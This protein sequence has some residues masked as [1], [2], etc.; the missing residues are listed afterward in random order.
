MGKSYPLFYTYLS[1][2]KVKWN[3]NMNLPISHS[4]VYEGVIL[5]ENRVYVAYRM[6]AY[7]ATVKALLSTLLNVLGVPETQ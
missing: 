7:I 1:D 5:I 6:P 4:M 2:I 3:I